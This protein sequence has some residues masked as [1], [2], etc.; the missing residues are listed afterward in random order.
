[1]RERVRLLLPR[2]VPGGLGAS[3]APSVIRYVRVEERWLAFVVP[4]PRDF[5]LVGF[6][7]SVPG[8]H[9]LA[10]ADSTWHR[11]AP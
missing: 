11:A 10:P 3:G 4:G 2:R 8:V 5:V 1:M 9:L 7:P 6:D